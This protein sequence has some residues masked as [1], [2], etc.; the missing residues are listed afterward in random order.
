VFAATAQ[1]GLNI[2]SK[3]RSGKALAANFLLFHRSQ[4][5][6]ISLPPPDIIS[7]KWSRVQLKFSFGNTQRDRP[8]NVPNGRAQRSDLR[9]VGIERG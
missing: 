9:E 1:G 8:F 3:I 5:S 7:E 2:K 4:A 6:R